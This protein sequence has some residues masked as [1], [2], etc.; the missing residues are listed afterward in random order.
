MIINGFRFLLTK[1]SV[2]PYIKLL[3]KYI[4]MWFN[5]PATGR[6][7]SY[8]QKV[9]FECPMRFSKCLRAKIY[10]CIFCNQSGCGVSHL[11]CAFLIFG[12]PVAYLSPALPKSTNK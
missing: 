2:I 1:A 6:N 4:N 5:R 12:T 9:N 11:G 8:E 7:Y 3:L 10:D